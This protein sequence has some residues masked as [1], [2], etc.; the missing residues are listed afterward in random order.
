MKF[1]CFV[2]VSFCLATFG[3]GQINLTS[4]LVAYYPFSGNAND[5]SGNGNNAVFNS[6]T[7]TAD[8]FGNAN[9]AYLFNGTSSYIRVANRLQQP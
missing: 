7:L 9:S 6:A 3:F 8:Q 2:L 4:G 1:V 5:Q